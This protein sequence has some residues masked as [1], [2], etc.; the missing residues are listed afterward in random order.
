MLNRSRIKV[1]VA[2]LNSALPTSVGLQLSSVVVVFVVFLFVCFIQ[3]K[4]TL[5]GKKKYLSRVPVAVLM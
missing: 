4:M 1:G 5:F 2:T 3:M